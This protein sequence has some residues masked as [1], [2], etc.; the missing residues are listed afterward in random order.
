MHDRDFLATTKLT[1]VINLELVGAA[2]LGALACVAILLVFAPRLAKVTI[3]RQRFREHLRFMN[4]FVQWDSSS[5]ADAGHGL[6]K[7]VKGKLHKGGLSGA[8]FARLMQRWCERAL[9]ESR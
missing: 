8:D 5:L 1:N 2:I 4:E 3:D 6:K 9:S 7:K